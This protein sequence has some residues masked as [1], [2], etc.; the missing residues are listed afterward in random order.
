MMMGRIVHLQ[1]FVKNL[2]F[3]TPF[4]ETISLNDDMIPENNGVFRIYIDA[5]GGKAERVDT[6]E[7]AKAMDIAELGRILFDKMRIFINELV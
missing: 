2:R 3:S 6:R 7:N 4:Y 5:A 1:N